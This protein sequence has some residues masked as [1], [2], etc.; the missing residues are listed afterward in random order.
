MAN[1]HSINIKGI[2]KDKIDIVTAKKIIKLLVVEELR[3]E[4]INEIDALY[5]LRAKIDFETMKIRT[6]N[7]NNKIQIECNKKER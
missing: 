7:S 3:A 5:I 4:I 6:I 1:K 2:C